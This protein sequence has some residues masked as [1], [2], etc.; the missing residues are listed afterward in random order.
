MSKRRVVITGMHAIS[1]L[2]STQEEIMAALKAKR[3]FTRCME[4]WES[5]TRFNS[6]FA[7]PLPK[8]EKPADFTR[9]HLRTMSTVSVMSVDCSREA[10]RAA[11]LENA[12][13][14]SNGRTGVAYGSCSGSLHATQA[15]VKLLFE[16]SAMD[17]NSSTYIKMMGQTAAVNIS[18]FFKT[19][20]RLFNSS[21]ACTSGS[22]AIGMAYEAISCGKQDI[23]I[24]GGADS[25]NVVQTAV[26]DTLFATWSAKCPAELAPAPFN[27]GRAGLVLGE[28]ACTLILEELEHAL[29]RG[30]NIIAEIVGFATNTDGAHI[31]SPNTDTMA[32]AMQEA[33][34][35]AQ[36]EPHQIGY[37]SAHGTGTTQGDIAES[38][39][40]ERIFGSHI[41]ISTLKSYTGHTLGACGALEAM[42]AIIMMNEGWFHPNLNLVEPDANCG[43]LDYIMHDGREI[44][45]EYIMSNNFAFGGI[46]TS[47]I[48]RKWNGQ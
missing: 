33:L 27:T 22:M 6:I 28:G 10:I 20:G 44:Q 14:L 32:I 2:G 48:F 16:N 24:A 36:L 40:T 3:N 21:T 11:G 9:K 35:D 47:L 29:A 25:F 12:E 1:T 45:P 7:A 4:E 39:A 41:P 13:E 34:Q 5:I 37:I 42:V 38:T 43:K 30:A 15:C 46:N 8:Y 17:M 19:K 18:L 31:T 26:F 23:M